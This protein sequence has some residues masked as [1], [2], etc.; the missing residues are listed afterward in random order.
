MFSLLPLPRR[1]LG[2]SLMLVGLLDPANAL[3]A[4]ALSAVLVHGIRLGP[5]AAVTAVFAVALTVTAGSVLSTVAAGM[6]GPGSRRGHDTGTVVM[7]ILTSSPAWRAAS[8]S[9]Q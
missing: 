5:A 3:A 8:R 2:W 4:I 6:L 7:A 1:R 9:R